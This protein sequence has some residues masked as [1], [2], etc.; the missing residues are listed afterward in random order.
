MAS[1]LAERLRRARAASGEDVAALAKRAGVRAE[2]LSAIEDGRFG[3]LPPGIYGRSAV[4]A[5]AAAYQ[6][7]PAEALA[8]CEAL[9]RPVDDPIAA[10]ARLTGLRTPDKPASSDQAT[11]QPD[12]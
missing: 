1:G 6:L 8:D 12:Q 3:D 10:L 9:L 4:R 7:D 5:F 11:A 2:H